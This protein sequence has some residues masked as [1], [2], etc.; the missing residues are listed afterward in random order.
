MVAAQIGDDQIILNSADHHWTK[1]DEIVVVTDG[2][3]GSI[4]QNEQRKIVE[5]HGQTITLDLP[6][7]F[8]HSPKTVDFGGI[9]RYLEK[10]LFRY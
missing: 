9:T 4:E 1:G 7:Q 10:W 5:I 6:F 3:P 8:N 2:G